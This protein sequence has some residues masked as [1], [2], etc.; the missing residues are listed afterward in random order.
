MKFV[1][2]TPHSCEVMRPFKGLSVEIAT[3][4][5]PLKLHND[6]DDDPSNEPYICQRYVEAVTGA[7]FKIKVSLHK[8]F[9]LRF[10]ARDDA[11][12]ITV[13]YDGQKQGFYNDLTKATIVKQWS[14][15]EPAELTFSRIPNFCEETQQWKQGTTTFGALDMSKVH[16]SASRMSGSHY[17]YRGDCGFPSFLV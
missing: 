11:V 14:E 4:T 10:M 2:S 9:P 16:C 12:H 1:T 7:T 13:F 3:Q 6:P 17:L 8:S 15:G 5:G